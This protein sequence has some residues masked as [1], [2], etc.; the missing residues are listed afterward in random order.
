MCAVVQAS[1][2]CAVCAHGIHRIHQPHV[3]SYIFGFESSF[4]K[5][6]ESD[7]QP[8]LQ[9]PV[10]HIFLATGSVFVSVQFM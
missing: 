4:L 2:N 10:I 7:L 6:R 5:L 9:S 8:N 1:V 3:A